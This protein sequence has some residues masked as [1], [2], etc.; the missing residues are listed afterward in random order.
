MQTSDGRDVEIDFVGS[1]S[2]G[3]FIL[4]LKTKKSAERNS[5]TELNAYSNVLD[6][7]APFNNTKKN[8]NVLISNF[9][10]GISKE[11][12]LFDLIHNERNIIVY[13]YNIDDAK[14]KLVPFVPS[15]QEFG[16]Y[17]KST[18]SRY[19]FEKFSISLPAV[20]GFSAPKPHAAMDMLAVSEVSKICSA[21][22]N[23]L[24]A[25]GLH[26]YVM[27]KVVRGEE[28]GQHYPINCPYKIYIYLMNPYFRSD[29]DALK[30][31]GRC[32]K[33]ITEECSKHLGGLVHTFTSGIDEDLL[34]IG[35]VTYFYSFGLIEDLYR[36]WLSS[37]WATVYL[38]GSNQRNPRYDDMENAAKFVIFLDQV[39]WD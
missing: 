19:T 37:L 18:L 30:F 33:K 20:P 5:A 36:F 29:G 22:L 39:G 11:A 31:R 9:E 26:G 6:R 38:D 24:R 3:D 34:W 28:I 21:F 16:A 10:S 1:C 2:L 27:G 4:E 23:G 13:N 7:S 8:I 17:R 32:H 35:P 14:I 12:Y 25:H 15:D